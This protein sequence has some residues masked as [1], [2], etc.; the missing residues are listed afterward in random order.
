[1]TPLISSMVI[2]F[3]TLY[4]FFVQGL[5]SSIFMAEGAIV[6]KPPLISSSAL[7]PP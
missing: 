3:G 2:S 5:V 4:G 7:L 1:M 6:Y